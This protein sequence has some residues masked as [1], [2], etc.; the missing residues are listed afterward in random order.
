VLALTLLLSSS[1]ASAPQAPVLELRGRRGPGPPDRDVAQTIWF[2]GFLADG[3]T[4]EPVSA[5]YD[6]VVEMFDADL[7]VIGS[8][9]DRHIYCYLNGGWR[10]LD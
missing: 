8:E 2:Q 4:G 6:V 7:C 1:A 5:A 3:T 9:G 10:R